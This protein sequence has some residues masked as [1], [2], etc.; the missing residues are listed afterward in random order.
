MIDRSTFIGG[1]DSAAVVRRDPRR[2]RVALYLEKRGEL[3]G[4]AETERMT[5]GNDL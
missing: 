3:P 5:R 1:S 4:A 2:T